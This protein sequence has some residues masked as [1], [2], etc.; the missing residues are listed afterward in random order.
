MEKYAN[1]LV[2]V[3]KKTAGGMIWFHKWGSL[4]IANNWAAFLLGASRLEPKLPRAGEYAMMAIDQ[5]GYALGDKG[6]SFVQGFGENPPTRSHHRAA[7]CPKAPSSCSNMLN[8]SQPNH[9]VLFGALVGGPNF[10]DQYKDVRNDYIM[11]EV[12]IDYNAGF[13]YSVSALKSILLK[14]N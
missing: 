8:S 14:R 4:R 6:R 3:E 5:I 11:N 2:D 13:Q 1:Y 10:Y 9:W 7:S 12:A